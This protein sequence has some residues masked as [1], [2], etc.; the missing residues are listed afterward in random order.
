[1]YQSIKIQPQ[2]R[3]KQRTV[4]TGGLKGVN[5]LQAPEFTP[6]NMVQAMQNYFIE[7]DGNLVK[8]KGAT[9]LFSVTS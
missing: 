3:Q 2:A 4:S 7:Q 6:E 5:L 8:R 9:L 1:M